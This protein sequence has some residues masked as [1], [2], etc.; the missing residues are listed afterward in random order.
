[1]RNMVSQTLYASPRYLRL[2]LFKEP[3]HLAVDFLY[4]FTNTLNK[5]T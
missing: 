4:S 2:G 5:H 1:M 3:G